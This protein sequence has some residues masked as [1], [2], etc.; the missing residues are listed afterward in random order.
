MAPTPPDLRREG[1]VRRPGGRKAALAALLAGSS[2]V[3]GCDAPVE[4]IACAAPTVV[5]SSV[6]PSPNNVLSAIVSAEVRSADSV[7]VRFGRAAAAMD[8]VTP[9]VTPLADSVVMPLFALHPAA[10]YGMQVIAFNRCAQTVG[11]V[12]SFATGTLPSDLPS[13]SAAG[14]D[15]SPGYVV[16]G[17]GKYGLVIDNAGRVVWYHR[18]PNGP[19]LNFQAQPNGRYVARPTPATAGEVARWVE[20][21]PLGTITRTLGCARGLQSRFHE[22]LAEPDGSYWLLCDEVR[23]VNLSAAGGSSQATVMGTAVQHLSVTGDVLFDWTPFD[24]LKI[25]LQALPAGDQAG[26]VINWTHGNALDLD[27]AGNLLVSFRNLSEVTK[28]NTRTGA[29]VWRMGGPR[30]QFTLENIGAP[31]FSR[32]HGVRATGAGRFLLLDNLGDPLASRAE[33]YEFDEARL[34]VRL[35]ASYASSTGAVA[36]TGGTTQSLPGGRTLVSYGSG[37]SVEEYDAAGN[38]V[39]KIE[40]K[41][42]YVFRAQ[43]IRSLYRP[44]AGDPR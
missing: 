21:D 25:D 27:S 14:P 9:A 7:A 37:G 24:H 17:A 2:L 8:A 35:S 18:F 16:F 29:V 43:R 22:M 6:A 38:V 1:T 12:L 20:I 34:T 30:N 33:R 40:G 4:P 28:I 3:I 10:D 13:Y 11:P 31:A 26:G 42:G 39:W 41:P 23:T 44:G 19:G 15:P 36:Q 5:R 32:Q